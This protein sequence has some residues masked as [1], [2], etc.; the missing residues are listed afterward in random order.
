MPR[1]GAFWCDL[2]GAVAAMS[3]WHA[4]L[5][6]TIQIHWGISKNRRA[7]NRAVGGRLGASIWSVKSLI[8]PSVTRTARAVRWSKPASAPGRRRPPHAEPVDHA[9]QA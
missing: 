1:F 8:A 9:W 7:Q 4:R 3:H 5:D 2:P 6:T